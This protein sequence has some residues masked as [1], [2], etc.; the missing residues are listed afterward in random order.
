MPFEKYI[1]KKTTSPR[2]EKKAFMLNKSVWLNYLVA[3]KEWKAIDIFYD[4]R[5]KQIA[6]T[7]GDTLTGRIGN[8]RSGRYI[9]LVGF[10]REFGLK[11]ER[12]IF[13]EH[14]NGLDIYER[15]K[16]D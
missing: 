13:K 9:S 4:R 12:W 11:H 8:G 10:M 15:E 16:H 1:Y 3:P 14:K 6:I 2:K 7:E 5:E